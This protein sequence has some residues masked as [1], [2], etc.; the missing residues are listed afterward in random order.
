[1]NSQMNFQKSSVC[2]SS[3]MNSQMNF[4]KSSVCKRSQMNS[5]MNFQKRCVCKSSQMNS[6]KLPDEFF[7]S[8][9]TFGPFCPISQHFAKG[10]AFRNSS[11]LS[12]F[13]LFP[14]FLNCMFIMWRL[15]NYSYYRLLQ[16]QTE[17]YMLLSKPS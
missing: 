1:M 14:H 8:F 13:C 5:Q 16:N 10:V 3:Q 15:R 4:Q 17:N 12:I 11:I 2:K 9:L 7:S 6:P